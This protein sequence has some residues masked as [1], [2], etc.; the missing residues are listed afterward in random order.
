MEFW[1]GLSVIVAATFIATWFNDK[2][3][4]GDYINDEA[5]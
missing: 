5:A 2:I 3:S 1:T 4:K